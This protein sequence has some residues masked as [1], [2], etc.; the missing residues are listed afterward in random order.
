MARIGAA[1]RRLAAQSPVFGPT[2]DE[3]ASTLAA[4]CSAPSHPDHGSALELAESLSIL[5]P[6]QFRAGLIG[7]SELSDAAIH[8]SIRLLQG[9][10]TPQGT[11][12]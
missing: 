9:A 11:N 2:S 4:V 5:T 10:L 3:I 6:A 8:F 7:A 1:E 12:H